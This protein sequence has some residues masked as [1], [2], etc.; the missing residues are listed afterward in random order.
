MKFSTSENTKKIFIVGLVGAACYSIAGPL[1][2]LAG[3]AVF[4]LWRA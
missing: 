2:C 1:G 4:F 3:L